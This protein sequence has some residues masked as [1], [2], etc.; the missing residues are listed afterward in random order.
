MHCRR[1]EKNSPPSLRI[2]VQKTKEEKSKQNKMGFQGTKKG[3]SYWF[4][5]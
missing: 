3:N 5:L 2:Y 1:E 4:I